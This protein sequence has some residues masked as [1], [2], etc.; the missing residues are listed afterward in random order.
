MSNITE[1][2]FVLHIILVN[3]PTWWLNRLPSNCT[4]TP[5]M[6]CYR[7]LYTSLE[8]QQTKN[9]QFTTSVCFTVSVQK[10]PL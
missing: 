7:T 5:V 1:L 2:K 6:P 3:M 10:I 9:L 8:M 4:C